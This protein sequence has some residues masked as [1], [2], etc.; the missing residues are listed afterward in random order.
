MVGEDMEKMN[1][2]TKRSK[3]RAWLSGGYPEFT[4]SKSDFYEEYNVED[5]ELD[6]AEE[7]TMS[8]QEDEAA[9]ILEVDQMMDQDDEMEDLQSENTWA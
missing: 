7:N 6:I 8:Q 5:A 2:Y 9:G 4:K 3:T 1:F